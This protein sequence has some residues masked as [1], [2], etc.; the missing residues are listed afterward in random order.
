VAA[1]G[2][3]RVL[4][5]LLGHDHLDGVVSIFDI[6]RD[7][8]PMWSS[9]D[10]YDPARA[11]WYTRQVLDSHLVHGDELV[12]PELIMA[13]ICESRLDNLI[14]GNNAKNGSSNP[15]LGVSWMQLDT[16][17]HVASIEM[18]HALRADPMVALRYVVQTPDLCTLDEHGMTAFNK[19]R[20]YGWDED[21]FD[22]LKYL[23][24]ITPRQAAMD[25]WEKVWG[26]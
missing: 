9:A 13:M 1:G 24:V 8:P 16:G 19:G 7:L 17:Y 12:V 6:E 15:Y 26:C 4:C 10:G 18:M 5:G 21:K 23:V 20:W 11:E 22:D 2:H 25:A 3:G 14:I